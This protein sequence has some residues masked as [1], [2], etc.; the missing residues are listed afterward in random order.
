MLRRF[1]AYYRPYLLDSLN[2]RPLEMDANNTRLVRYTDSS[3]TKKGC[4]LSCSM[5]Y[6]T[7]LSYLDPIL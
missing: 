2:R 5:T 6:G 7:S 4:L 3:N 1:M